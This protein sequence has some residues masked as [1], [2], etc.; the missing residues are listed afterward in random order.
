MIYDLI[1][2]PKKVRTL[3]VLESPHTD[4]LSMGY[5]VAGK[6]GKNMSRAIL[7]DDSVALGR[8]LYEQNELVEEYGIFNSCQFPLGLADDLADRE[9]EFSKIK[10]IEQ[11][12]NRS[13]N[14]RNLSKFLDVYQDLDALLHYKSRLTQILNDSPTIETIV[15]C[16]FI[17]QAIFLNLYPT[18]PIP[19]FNRIHIL[20][21]PKTGVSKKILFVN[22][23]SEINGNKWVYNLK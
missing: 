6:T 18:I 8:L 19:P 2:Y 7:K 15:F 21:N 13:E 1:P 10:D 22:H 14:Y 4:E 16:G 11:G 5:P 9:K 23:P 17:A 20:Q 12:S 3:F